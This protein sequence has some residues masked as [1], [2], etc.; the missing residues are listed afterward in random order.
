MSMGIALDEGDL[1][2]LKV[3][4]DTTLSMIEGEMIGMEKE[5]S[6]HVTR[7]EA[8]EITRRKTADLF[9]AA[10]RAGAQLSEAPPEVTDRLASF[11]DLLGIAF[12]MA[13]DL[14]DYSETSGKPR[15][16]DIRERVVSLPLIY[17]TED[18]AV[19]PRVRELLSGSPSEADIERIQQLV[20]ASGALERVGQDARKL[21]ANAIRELE[22]VEL[23]GIRPVLVDLAMSAVDRSH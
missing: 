8:L 11:G 20:T 16:Q 17:A 23:N 21:A 12:Q 5:G 22:R 6:V 10:C 1:T 9:S 4:S 15:G 7:E 3:L 13:D 14:L 2:I 19:G 18:E